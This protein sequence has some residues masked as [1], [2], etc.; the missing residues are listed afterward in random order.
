[1]ID[2]TS[3][4]EGRFA[5]GETV[6]VLDQAG[7]HQYPLAGIATYAGQDDAAGAQVVAFAAET[8]ASVLG[9]PGR[10]DALLVVAAPGVSQSEVV[11][12]IDA[13]LSR[14][15]LEVLTGTEATDQAQR[16]GWRL[17]GFPEHVPDDVRARRSG[18][19]L[20]R[21]L[22]HVLDHSRATVRVTPQ[23]C[24]RSVPSADRSCAR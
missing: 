9:E 19:R 16:R 22:Q 3:A 15:D 21:D 20:V 18:G 13:A 2:V 6:T 4:T 11:G 24:G 10:Y 23:C 1:M 5:V 14:P 7:A 17:H 12:A 8:A